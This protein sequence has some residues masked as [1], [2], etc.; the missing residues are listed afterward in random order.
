MNNAYQRQKV[1]TMSRE[2]LIRTSADTWRLLRGCLVLYKPSGVTMAQVRD[3]TRE[4]LTEELNEMD[5]GEK[6]EAL[7]KKWGENN[8]NSTFFALATTGAWGKISIVSMYLFL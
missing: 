8:T 1:G 6:E 3:N 7:R 5:L 2:R 4:R